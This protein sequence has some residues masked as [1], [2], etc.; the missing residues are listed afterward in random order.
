M[1]LNSL[2]VSGELEI[3][4]AYL[5]NITKGLFLPVLPPENPSVHSF[6]S[7]FFESYL[8]ALKKVATD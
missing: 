4:C 2:C 8:N 7:Q 1:A 5:E 6:L 3:L